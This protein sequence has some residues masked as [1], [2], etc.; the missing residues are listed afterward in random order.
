MSSTTPLRPLGIGEKLDAAIKIYLRNAPQL[1]LTVLV[2]V[3]PLQLLAAIVSYGLLSGGNVHN[4]KIYSLSAGSILLAALF[5]VVISIVQAA[6]ANAACFKGVSDA[7]VGNPMSWRE[8]LRFTL[9][10]L[11]S[12]VWLSVMVGFLLIIAA[13]ALLVPAIYL[14]VIWSLAFPVLVVEGLRGTKAMGRSF[15]L[16]RG[17]WWGTF[18]T[19]VVAF[20][21]LYV[22]QFIVGLILGAITNSTDSFALIRAVGFVTG[23]ITS[24]I[25]TP[26]I[27]ACVSVIYYDLRVRKEG[28]DIEM[29]TQQLGT[30]SAAPG[31]SA[32]PAPAPASG[33]VGGLPS[34]D[35]PSGLER[36]PQAPPPGGPPPPPG[37]PPRSPGG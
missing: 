13:I 33:P 22:V 19:L 36:G 25:A 31:S 14:G 20:I 12:L 24:V 35:E 3:V 27:A 8:S 32:A 15:D 10:K 26:F 37:G 5:S 1:F 34:S 9:P 2:V 18:G 6:L 23:V 16:V 29:L 7:Y 4:G 30:A 28:F 11:G 17:H 21:L